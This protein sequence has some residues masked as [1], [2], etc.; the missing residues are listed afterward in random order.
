MD[1]YK[2]YQMWAALRKATVLSLKGDSMEN[3]AK[4]W[5]GIG[6]C[7]EKDDIEYIHSFFFLNTHSKLNLIIVYLT[8]G[9]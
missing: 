6:V 5:R 8:E 1:A 9:S 3:I 2:T 7:L 4:M